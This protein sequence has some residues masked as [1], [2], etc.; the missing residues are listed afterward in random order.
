M[1]GH[2]FSNRAPLFV[3]VE[4]FSKFGCFFG[5]SAQLLAFFPS[6]VVT[7]S[8]CNSLGPLGLGAAVFG[9]GFGVAS[10]LSPEEGE[11][12]V[13]ENGHLACGE[14]KTKHVEADRTAR[15][16]IIC[17]GSRTS[18]HALS[19]WTLYLGRPSQW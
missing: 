4:V 9:C 16:C 6:D 5:R 3:T 1:I 8:I 14:A 11:P 10:A 2:V 19:S 7:A 15:N 17:T 18:T 12:P 13:F